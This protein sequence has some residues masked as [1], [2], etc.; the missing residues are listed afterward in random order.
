[1]L[2]WDERKVF[3]LPLDEVRRQFLDPAASS[4]WFP[5]FLRVSHGGRVDLLLGP[6]DPIRLTLVS[7]TWSDDLNDAS[8]TAACPAFELS[9]YLTLRAVIAGTSPSGEMRGAVEVWIH[10]E[11]TESPQGRIALA[12]AQT[13]TR[14]GLGRMAAELNPL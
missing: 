5:D 1:V 11:T 12:R 6:R 3:A 10:M 8:F 4:F 14:D 9:G 13:A 7:E 2:G